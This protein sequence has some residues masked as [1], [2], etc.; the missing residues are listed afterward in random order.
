MWVEAAEWSIEE[1]ETRLRYTLEFN[2]DT[3]KWPH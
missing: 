3:Q 1:T 2:I